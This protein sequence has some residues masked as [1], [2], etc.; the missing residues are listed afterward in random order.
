[1]MTVHVITVEKQ[2]PNSIIVDFYKRQIKTI[3]IK[4]TRESL[5]KYIMSLHISLDS[6]LIM[7]EN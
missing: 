3:A 1:M 2:V 5:Y 7:Q 4:G 6:L